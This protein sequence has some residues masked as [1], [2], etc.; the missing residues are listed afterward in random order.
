MGEEFFSSLLAE[1]K[2]VLSSTQHEQFKRYFELLVEWNEKMNLTAITEKKDVYLKHFYDS[3]TPSFYYPFTDQKIV[4][5]GAGA[6]FPSLPLK[7]LYPDLQISIIDSLNKRIGFLTHLANELELTGVSFYHDRA[8]LAGKSKHHREIYDVA[9]ARA[10]A[11]MSVLS[12]LCLPFVKVGGDFI[13][14]KGAGSNEEVA[15]GKKAIAVLG[16]ELSASHSFQLPIE[17]SER[18]IVQIKKAKATP[19]KYLRKPGVPNKQ[20]IT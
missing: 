12:E 16:G 17:H 1:Q 7:I 11:R 5:I 2:I 8:E 4:D 6:G 20:P 9:I 14:L 18:Q 10:V 19:N 3:I 13:A 15:E